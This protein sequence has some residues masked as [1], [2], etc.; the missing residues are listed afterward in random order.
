VFVVLNVALLRVDREILI[1]AD[2]A[3]DRNRIE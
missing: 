1:T 2:V 3:L